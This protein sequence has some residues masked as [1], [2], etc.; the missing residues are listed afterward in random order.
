MYIFLRGVKLQSGNFH[1]AKATSF[2]P[3]KLITCTSIIHSM[4][5]NLILIVLISPLFYTNWAFKTSYLT[6]DPR[7]KWVLDLLTIS[8]R[9]HHWQGTCNAVWAQQKPHS[10][11]ISLAGGRESASSRTSGETQKREMRPIRDKKGFRYGEKGFRAGWNMCFR[12]GRTQ[13]LFHL[14][15]GLPQASQDRKHMHY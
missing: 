4:R 11:C 5:Y 9:V 13:I 1:S 14:P 7:V 10:K 15:L 2:P 3:L 6:D 8:E 12:I